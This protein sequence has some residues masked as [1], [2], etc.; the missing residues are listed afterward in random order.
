MIQ[1][2][3]NASQWPVECRWTEWIENVPCQT[4]QREWSETHRRVLLLEAE[5][6]RIVCV[7]ERG[8]SEGVRRHYLGLLWRVAK[9]ARQVTFDPHLA[10]SASQ[11]QS[12]TQYVYLRLTSHL[13]NI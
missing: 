7:R 5:V 10:F 6:S 4:V 2:G 9:C 1:I 8:G 11:I 3:S 13:P 12:H